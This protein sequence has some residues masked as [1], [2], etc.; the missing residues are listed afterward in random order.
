MAFNKKLGGVYW[1]QADYAHVQ[2]LWENFHCNSL[3]QY[4]EL[5]IMSD[6]SLLA[7]VFQALQNQSLDEY[8]L[9]PHTL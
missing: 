5:Y 6:I 7:E 3:K 8:Q 9:D 2:Q 4:I 1:T